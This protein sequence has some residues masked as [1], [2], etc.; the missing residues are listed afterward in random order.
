MLGNNRHATLDMFSEMENGER[1]KRAGLV[2]HVF[3]GAGRA[4]EI[5]RCLK[6]GRGK[7]ATRDR[8]VRFAVQQ[9]EEKSERKEKRKWE[10]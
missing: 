6:R 3:L 5:K 4:S 10:W 2:S 1:E 9:V 8:G 7:C